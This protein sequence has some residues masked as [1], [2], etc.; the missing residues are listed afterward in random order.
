LLTRHA[1]PTARAACLGAITREYGGQVTTVDFAR[2]EG[3]PVLVTVIDGTR[4]AGGRHLVVVVGPD[5]GLGGA[6]ADERYRGT[7]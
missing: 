6:I 4:V 1:D 3:Q 2:F 7:V 5:C